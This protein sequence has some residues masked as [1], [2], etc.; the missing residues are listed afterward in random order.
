MDRVQAPLH[1]L[2]AELVACERVQVK[3]GDVRQNRVGA[4]REDAGTK[5]YRG[6]RQRYGGVYAIR[7]IGAGSRHSNLRST[8]CKAR[9]ARCVPSPTLGILENIL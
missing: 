8:M 6:Q 9:A 4:G 3:Q 5:E 7:P 2:R 1:Q